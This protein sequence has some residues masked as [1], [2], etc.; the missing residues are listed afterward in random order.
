MVGWDHI[1][2]NAKIFVL[3]KSSFKWDKKRN[4][5]F[6]VFE[7]PQESAIYPSDVVAADYVVSISSTPGWS[8][9]KTL[10][11]KLHSDFRHV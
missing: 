6:S 9:C 1:Q 8:L 2:I 7:D 10:D 3:G 4:I 11:L 5:Q